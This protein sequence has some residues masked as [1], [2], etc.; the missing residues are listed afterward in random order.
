MENELSRVAWTFRR[1]DRWTKIHIQTDAGSPAVEIAPN[2]IRAQVRLNDGTLVASTGSDG[3][4]EGVIQLL[5]TEST[6]VSAET[7]I[8]EWESSGSTT[9]APSGIAWFECDGLDT[10]EGSIT[11]IPKRRFYIVDQ[12]ARD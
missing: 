5:F 7:P 10:N 1:G 3:A 2:T 9:D 4:A 11:I 6:D 12:I 8:I